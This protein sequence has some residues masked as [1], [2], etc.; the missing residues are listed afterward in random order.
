MIMHASGENT[1][2][3]HIEILGPL[4]IRTGET[5]RAIPAKKVRALLA[6]LALNGQHFVSF[7]EMVDELWAEST[8]QNARNALHANALRLRKQLQLC[9]SGFPGRELL[10]TS[11]NGYVLDIEPESLD[12]NQFQRLADRGSELRRSRPREAIGLWRTALSLWRGPALVDAGDGLRCR[13]AAL[14][15]EERRINVQEDLVGAEIEAGGARSAVA[16]L[17]QLVARYPERER[18]SEQLMLALYRC[19]R[20]A[21]ALDVFHRT[22]QWLGNQLGVEPQRPLQ[23]MYQ[24]ILVQDPALVLHGDS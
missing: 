8:L 10:R 23:V 19:G 20:Q 3:V 17:R 14:R 18:L 16:E 22:R 5:R 12:A 1:V 21:E 4:S 6:L 9:E 2:P 15:L 13:A 11:A 7:D 24:A